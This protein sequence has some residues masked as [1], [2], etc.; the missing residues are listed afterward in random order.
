MCIFRPA[1]TTDDDGSLRFT[2]GGDLVFETGAGGQVQFMTA[3]G[4]ISTIGQ[5]VKKELFWSI[6]TGAHG[7]S[8]DDKIWSSHI[9]TVFP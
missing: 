2:S 6:Y 7:M 5:K 1:I 8:S 9:Y 3:D 4:P